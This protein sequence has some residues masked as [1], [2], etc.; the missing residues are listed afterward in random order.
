MLICIK[1]GYHYTIECTDEAGTFK[2]NH[3]TNVLRLN[4][5]ERSD[6]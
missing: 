4:P 1:I 2:V 6:P 3:E 5:R